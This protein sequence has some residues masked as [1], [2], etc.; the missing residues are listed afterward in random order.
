M[1]LDSSL[2]I[3]NQEFSLIPRCKDIWD[4]WWWCKWYKQLYCADDSSQIAQKAPTHSNVY[5]IKWNVKSKLICASFPYHSSPSEHSKCVGIMGNPLALFCAIS[6]RWCL[7][8]SWGMFLQCSCLLGFML[9]I[10]RALF[11]FPPSQQNLSG[12][13]TKRKNITN[14]FNLRV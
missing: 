3:F 2:A 6:F 14:I 10:Y 9:T 4:W 13:G 8:N 5:A 1:D 11:R 12:G 7:W